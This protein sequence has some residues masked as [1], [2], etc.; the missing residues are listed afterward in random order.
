MTNPSS[1]RWVGWRA[2]RRRAGNA[3]V[4]RPVPSLPSRPL[5]PPRLWAPPAPRTADCATCWGQRMIWEPG[6][7]GLLPVVCDGCGGTGKT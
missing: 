5:V 1:S 3:G 2:E 4:E 7:L 6:P